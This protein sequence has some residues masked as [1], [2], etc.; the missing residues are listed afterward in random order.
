MITEQHSPVENELSIVQKGIT[1]TENAIKRIMS[2]SETEEQDGAMLRII[3]E[4]GGC[5]GFQYKYEFPV[6]DVN[7]KKDSGDILFKDK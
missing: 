2:L 7:Q 1:L 6:F 5:S 4:G 3:V